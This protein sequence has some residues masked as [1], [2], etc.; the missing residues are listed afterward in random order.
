[1]SDDRLHEIWKAATS[2]SECLKVDSSKT[3]AGTAGATT[4]FAVR[5]G[6]PMFTYYAQNPELG[7]RFAK[8]MA[9]P[10]RGKSAFKVILEGIVLLTMFQLIDM[11]SIPLK[12]FQNAST[13]SQKNALENLDPWIEMP[14]RGLN[15]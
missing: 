13:G 11:S 14:G 7:V 1:M 2:T 9:G 10:T 15:V 3:G 8:A 4:P 5:F 6:V 12:R